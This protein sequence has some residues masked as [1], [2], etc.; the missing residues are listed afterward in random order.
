MHSHYPPLFGFCLIH[1][2]LMHL[3]HKSYPRAD[4]P[5]MHSNTPLREC[6]YARRTGRS[7]GV[8][9][10]STV[11][12]FYEPPD[13]EHLLTEAAQRRENRWLKIY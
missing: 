6:A 11:V 4:L 1:F 8:N 9:G 5:C 13:L 2:H 10:I 7:S 12:F 3:V